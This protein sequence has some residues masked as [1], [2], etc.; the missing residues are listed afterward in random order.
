MSTIY[1]VLHS[2]GGYAREDLP[3][4]HAS[5]AYSLESDAMVHAIV[6]HGTVV[7]IELDY[8]PHGI[9]ANAKELGLW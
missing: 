8:M 3:T 9:V 1:V 5:G 2:V 6:V 7:P 4:T